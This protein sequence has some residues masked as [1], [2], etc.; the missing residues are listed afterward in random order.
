MANHKYHNIEREFCFTTSSILYVDL[1]RDG[2]L[3][4]MWGVGG[5]PAT[6]FCNT[7]MKKPG[8]C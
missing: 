1:V 8:S 2:Q 5:Y 7:N 4:L 3:E 6:P